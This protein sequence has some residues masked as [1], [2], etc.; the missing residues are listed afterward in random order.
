[1]ADRIATETRTTVTLVA[2]ALCL[3]LTAWATAPRR[4]APAA[5]RDL[6]Q[7]FFPAFV[8]PNAASSLEV[9]EFDVQ[10]VRP[11]PFKVLNRD[12]RWTIPSHDNYPADASNCLSSI[13]ASIV[14]MKKDDVASDSPNDQERCGVLDP[15]DETLPATEGR[16]TRVIV[17]GRN[18][19]TLAD[20]IIG[21]PVNGRAEFRYVRLPGER[22]TYVARVDN[23]KISTKFED[24][25]ERNLLQVSRDDL[26]QI[27][28]RNY[29]A[30]VRSGTVTRRE[31][32]VLHRSARDVW[33]LDGLSPGESIDGFTMNLLVTKLVDLSIED[34]R[35]KPPGITATLMAASPGQRLQ[36]ADVADL[37]GKGFYFGD[38]GQL[39]SNQGEV[40]VHTVSGIF[41]VL[42]F[43]EI[44]YE[45]RDSRYLFISV[46]FDPAASRGEVPD[47]VRKRLDVLRARFAAWYYLV[48]NDNF[49]KIRIQR[50]A[51]VRGRR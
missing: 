25:I 48:T 49:Q 29:S 30:D 38:D 23:L 28:I 46:G 14:A 45:P 9:V 35:P 15:L 6:G 13:A 12:G 36:P 16:G 50:A 39:L 26:D 31:M 5:L 41:Y 7:P 34:V 8:D 18:E 47:E 33:T 21:N 17:R 40:V 3:A 20:I 19:K 24:W 1:M 43:G 51:L 11:R 32:L 44:A 37:G 10:A 27:I 42:R 4:V 2:L 22:R